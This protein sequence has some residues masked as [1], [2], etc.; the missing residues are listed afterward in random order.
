MTSTHH[1]EAAVDPDAR[2]VHRTD[3]A[4]RAGGVGL[5][6]VCMEVRPDVRE[7][8]EL[9]RLLERLDQVQQR[10]VRGPSPYVA[11]KTSSSPMWV[12]M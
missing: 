12:S 4:H 7:R 1:E 8:D 11:R 3:V 2:R 10:D 9:P 5:D 6:D